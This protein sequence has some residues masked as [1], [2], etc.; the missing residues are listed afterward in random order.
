MIPSFLQGSRNI[1]F[2]RHFTQDAVY[3]DLI[4]NSFIAFIIRNMGVFLNLVFNISVARILGPS[5]LGTFSVML[6]LLLPL[7]VASRLGLDNLQV[8]LVPQLNVQ[9]DLQGKLTNYRIMVITI[10]IFSVIVSGIL[11][12]LVLLGNPLKQLA[13]SLVFIA[14]AA[15]LPLHALHFLNIQTLK[16]EMRIDLATFFENMAI[17]LIALGLLFIW[18]LVGFWGE[19]YGP[20]LAF[21]VAI[22]I[23]F[24]LSTYTV[25]HFSLR[26]LPR[27][28][29]PVNFIDRTTQHELLRQSFP[30]WCTALVSIALTSV[31]VLMLA[32]FL[33][34]ADVGVYTAGTKLISFMTFPLGAVINIAGPRFAEAYAKGDV[35]LLHDNFI[36]A[37]RLGV[38]GAMPILLLAVLLPGP[39]L[40]IFG[41]SFTHG[42]TVVHLLAIGQFVNV[43]AGPI[44]FF[45]LMTKRAITLQYIMWSTLSVSLLL[46]Y[47]LIPKMGI[48]GAAIAS[49]S[50]LIIRNIGCWIV[51]K[52]SFGFSALYLPGEE[53]IKSK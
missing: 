36:K 37:T 28:Q 23:V 42:V 50:A 52:R 25:T 31:D 34:K 51:V 3:R 1:K 26:S 27:I 4:T 11:L 15:V 39:L 49:L 13:P 43:I 20:V 38:W 19:N 8:R 46:N 33:P 53:L 40:S 35:D 7:S 9:G 16:G 32:A 29:T 45:L 47:L 41:S 22:L 44:A 21:C 12:F 17:W 24:P 18:R 10:M 2:W 30:I 48:N 6:S 14:I 5:G